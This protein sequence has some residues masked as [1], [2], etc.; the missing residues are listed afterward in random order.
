MTWA[1][2]VSLNG[3]NW[4]AGRVYR[5]V[6]FVSCFHIGFHQGLT[7]EFLIW[8]KRVFCFRIPNDL[9]KENIHELG[10]AH[11]CDSMRSPL[12]IKGTRTS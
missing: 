12:T 4:T 8:F 2:M 10:I 3:I 11:F 1:E 9:F 5:T 7:I 6:L